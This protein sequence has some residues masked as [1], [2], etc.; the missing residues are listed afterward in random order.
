M[1][2]KGFTLVE[3]LVVIGIITLL[4]IIVLPS[5]TKMN[6]TNNS[7]KYG[8]YEKMVAEYAESQGKTSRITNICDINGLPDVK[9]ECVGFV[10]YENQKYKP[11]L[12]CEKSGY[13]TSYGGNDDFTH[14][15]PSNMTFNLCG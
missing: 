12:K 11:Y 4:T 15:K 14:K 7:K 5:L 13:E 10:E 8:S 2:R 1:N 3:L 6:D 9:K